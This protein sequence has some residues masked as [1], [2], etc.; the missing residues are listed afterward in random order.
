VH[1]RLLPIALIGFVFA[2][3]T[4]WSC[5]KLDTT[6]LGS[7][8]IPAVD[9]VNTF[10]DIFPIISTQGNF[11][12][13][14]KVAGT[15]NH[16]LG[17][18]SNDPL[19]GTV[20]ANVFLQLK[21]AF[22]PF[23]F[24]ASSFDTIQP[25]NPAV[26]S[27]VLCLSYKGAWG[28]TTIPQQLQVYEVRDNNFRDSVLIYRKTSFEPVTTNLL[29]SATVNIAQL[30][31]QVRYNRGKDSTTAQIR[32]KL[33]ND[34]FNERLLQRD[35]SGNTLN[36]AFKTD[37][38]YR[39]FYNGLAVKAVNAGSNS[40]MYV[41]INDANTRLEIYYR[42]SK[43]GV[44]DTTYTTFNLYSDYDGTYGIYPSGSVNNIKR[45]KAGSES[46]SAPANGN[47]HYIQTSSGS[48]VDINIPALTMFK[49][50]NRIIHRAELIVQQI[51]DI[52]SFLD[53]NLSAPAYMYVDLKA[54]D[55]SYKPIYYD[56]NPDV[57]YDPDA[58]AAF[59]P[60]SLN[61]NYFGGYLRKRIDP[62]TGR[63]QG[64]YN[65]NIS[66]YLQ[67]MVIKDADNYRLR[68]YAPFSLD[69]GQYTS[70][71]IPYQ[72]P[73]AFG[74]IRIG[75]GTNPEPAYRMRLVVTWSKIK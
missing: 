66:R 16:A 29:G 34:L 17:F 38:I 18:I 57:F 62:V 28:D 19:F 4:N 32:I 26:D 22:Y 47:A 20:E 11:T 69:Y 50:T 49:D 63:S 46:A 2:F 71:S 73:I 75:S 9:N 74:R 1:K 61:Q 27:V 8:L 23:Y 7:D 51:P 3:A 10:R 56:L 21:P 64:Y 44:K 36:N 65:M 70:Q 67:R 35:T 68:L 48:F 45:N 42:K 33:T 58:A 6:S 13:S 39:R 43:S 30:K 55:T 5:T 12:D 54:T 25:Y 31:N 37:S 24:G 15:D 52:T 41:N 40:L 14:T 59:Y 60:S 53:S 72:N